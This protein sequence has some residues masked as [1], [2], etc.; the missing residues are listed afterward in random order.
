MFVKIG[1]LLRYCFE[2]CCVYYLVLVERCNVVYLF[3][4]GGEWKVVLRVVRGI[5][6]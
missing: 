3:G 6:V 5:K 2:W 4:K 1:Y